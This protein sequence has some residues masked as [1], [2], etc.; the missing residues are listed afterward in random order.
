VLLNW[1]GWHGLKLVWAITKPPETSNLY[2]KT[3]DEDRWNDRHTLSFLFLNAFQRIQQRYL[4]ERIQNLSSV[5]PQFS[6]S[7]VLDFTKLWCSTRV[8]WAQE[9]SQADC[10]FLVDRP[11]RCVSSTPTQTGRKGVHTPWNYIS[12]DMESTS[13]SKPA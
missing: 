7:M 8:S 4:L 2:H 12:H 10:T 9:F 13:F 5:H 1:K 3:W 11:R 6:W